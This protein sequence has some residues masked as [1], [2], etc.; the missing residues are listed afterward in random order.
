MKLGRHLTTLDTGQPA[1]PTNWSLHQ[2]GSPYPLAHGMGA[3]AAIETANAKTIESSADIL[4][5]EHSR[6][7]PSESIWPVP[8][9]N[10]SASGNRSASARIVLRAL[11][12]LLILSTSPSDSSPSAS[13][14]ARPPTATDR[15]AVQE[16]LC[17]MFPQGEARAGPYHRGP[18]RTAQTALFT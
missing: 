10:R 3:Q 16:I 7:F 1:L 18:S 8:H 4:L 14:T 9:A 17:Q 6:S 15:Q 2:L 11:V 12:V 5:L 13:M